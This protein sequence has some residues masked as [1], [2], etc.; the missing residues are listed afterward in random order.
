V[1]HVKLD[2]CEFRDRGPS[3]LA[4]IGLILLVLATSLLSAQ[5]QPAQGKPCT[6]VYDDSNPTWQAIRAQYAKLAH[7]MKR[8]DLNALFSL[9]TPDYH[10]VTTNGEVWTRE[11]S[12]QYQRNGME[13][14]I[15]TTHISNSIARLNVCQDEA[16]ATVMQLW[17]RRQKMA[18]KVREV[19]THT[20]QDEQWVKTPDG[21]KR[22]NIE[23]VAKGVA[24]IDGKR[25]DAT[26]PYDPNAP[27]YDPD[28]A[29]F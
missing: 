27:P 25:V 3:R 8:K 13:Q 16:I 2:V 15:E 4:R 23:H 21:W 17:Y 14:V 10:V 9:Y 28:N 18:G 6:E 12:L 29:T 11:K 19:E 5:Q 24:F 20:V 22:G 1:L 26:K 7:A